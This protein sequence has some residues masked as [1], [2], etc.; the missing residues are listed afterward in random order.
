MLDRTSSDNEETRRMHPWRYASPARIIINSARLAEILSIDVQWRLNATS[1]NLRRPYKGLITY[2]AAIREAY[3]RRKE[4]CEHEKVRIDKE[5]AS[6]NTQH[7]VAAIGDSSSPHNDYSDDNT[8]K[9][10]INNRTSA[11]FK[12]SCLERDLLECLITILDEDMQSIFELRRQISEGSLPQSGITYEDLWHL[13]KPGDI[14]IANPRMSRTKEKVYIVLHV[15]G[16]RLLGDARVERKADPNSAH[17]YRIG[18]WKPGLN[19]VSPAVS[20]FALDCFYI[21]H[22]GTNYGACGQPWIAYDYTGYKQVE[23]L[24]LIP[25]QFM[26]K[27]SD[28]YTSLVVQGKKLAGL[29][30]GTSKLYRGLTI[31]ETIENAEYGS[32][33]IELTP[34]KEVRESEAKMTKMPLTA[35]R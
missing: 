21:D 35:S 8:K 15:T 6:T 28:F 26:L 32:P 31:R 22:D 19:V 3:I 20:P 11:I 25:L 18:A 17:P 24:E 27:S 13:Y 34:L 4:H 9:Q 1:R 14:V 5:L 12:Q 29:Q 30:A 10:A 2:E 23:S 7:P 33:P 16:G